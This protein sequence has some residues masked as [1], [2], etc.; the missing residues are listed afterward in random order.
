MID[1]LRMLIPRL[2]LVAAFAA[3]SADA[4]T[5]YVPAP[6]KP[7]QRPAWNCRAQHSVGTAKIYASRQLDAAGT[8]LTDNASWTDTF[9][10][11]NNAP[12]TIS[13]DWH[14]HPSPM[15]FADG[16]TTFYFRTAQPMSGPIGVRLAGRR[17]IEIDAGQAYDNPRHF[18]AYER[19]GNVLDIAGDEG[20]LKWTLRGAVPGERGAPVAQGGAYTAGEL[21]ALEPGFAAALAQL[22]L[23]QADFARR[24]QRQSATM[25]L[26]GLPELL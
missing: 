18:S 17:T 15:R 11:D 2:W 16:M 23:M 21:R 9:T 24:C 10:A 1:A 4:Q 26:V 7:S 20:A 13:V 6:S 25:K 22:D 14:S 12:L 8:S 19:I 3:P 5:M